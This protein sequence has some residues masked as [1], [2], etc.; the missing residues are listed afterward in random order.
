[1]GAYDPRSG[2]E[3]GAVVGVLSGGCDLGD[4]DGGGVCG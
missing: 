2:G 4:G 1:M 3:V